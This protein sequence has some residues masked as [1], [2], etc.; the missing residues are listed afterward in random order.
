MRSNFIHLIENGLDN[1]VV[2]LLPISMVMT[3]TIIGNMMTFV[4]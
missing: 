2:S 1:K 3:T 4:T